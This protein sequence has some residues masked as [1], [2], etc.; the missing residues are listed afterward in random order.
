METENLQRLNNYQDKTIRKLRKDNARLRRRI[1]ALS[2]AS[3]GDV[4][5]ASVKSK[6]D[7]QIEP[8]KDCNGNHVGYVVSNFFRNLGEPE[9]FMQD[10]NRVCSMSKG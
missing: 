3:D 5:V 1:K 2:I 9:K 10:M 8:W 4:K 6:D 7:L